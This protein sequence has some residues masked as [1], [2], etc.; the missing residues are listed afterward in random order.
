[1]DFFFTKFNS[2][3]IHLNRSSSSGDVFLI[4]IFNIRQVNNMLRPM[5]KALGTSEQ[6]SSINILWKLSI[7]DYNSLSEICSAIF[8]YFTFCWR[9]LRCLVL[10]WIRVKASTSISNFEAN[11]NFTFYPKGSVVIPSCLMR[12]GYKVFINGRPRI[13]LQS[14]F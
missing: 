1:M 10:A 9:K 2:F 14:C 3:S 8:L 12:K 4:K 7:L 6:I 13:T 5:P 11:L